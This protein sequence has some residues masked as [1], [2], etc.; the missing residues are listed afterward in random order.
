MNSFSTSISTVEVLFAFWTLMSVRISSVV[1][2][3]G[4][5]AKVMC[6]LNITLLR[7]YHESSAFLVSEFG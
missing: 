7:G 5:A 1:H 2:N 6:E 3:S 4:G